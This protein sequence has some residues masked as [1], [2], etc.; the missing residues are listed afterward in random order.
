LLTDEVGHPALAQHLYLVIGFMKASSSWDGFI[1]ML[2]RV[3]QKKG[4]TIPLA[5][6]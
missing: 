3:V 4:Q 1:N 5:L 6:D 2:D